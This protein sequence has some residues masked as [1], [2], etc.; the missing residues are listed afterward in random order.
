MKNGNQILLPSN[1]AH[2]TQIRRQPNNNRNESDQF[3]ANSNIVKTSFAPYSSSASFAMDLTCIRMYITANVVYISL[4]LR[5]SLVNC[6]LCYIL[7]FKRTTILLL[8]AL[9]AVRHRN[10]LEFRNC[11]LRNCFTQ[12]FHI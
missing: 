11:H 9:A 6:K 7:S 1:Q 8:S 2:L 5:K 4:D 12:K 3:I 10:V